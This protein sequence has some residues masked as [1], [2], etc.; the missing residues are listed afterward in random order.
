LIH[1]DLKPANILIFEDARS[2]SLVPK[3]SDFAFS[4]TWKESQ[5]SGGTEYWNAP[6]CCELRSGPIG[7]PRSQ[8]RDYFSLGLVFWNVFRDEKPFQDIGSEEDASINIRRRI[9]MAK[10]S[11]HLIKRLT[12]L[13]ES[14]EY[15]R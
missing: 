15:V 1:G 13:K 9:Q 2:S 11:G 7:N 5:S 8:L 6:E 4:R 14:E 12:T 10:E 3:L